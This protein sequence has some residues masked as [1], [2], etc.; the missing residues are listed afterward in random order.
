MLRPPRPPSPRTVTVVSPP[1]RS[2][3]G[4]GTRLAVL[5][6]LQRDPGHD[7]ADLARLA[8]ERVA[9][10]QRR[11]AR[12]PRDLGRGLQARLGAGDH[13]GLV[14]GQP[15]VAGLGRLLRGALRGG[16]G[17]PAAAR[18]GSGPGCRARPRRWRG[19]VPWAP[20]RWPLGSSP[21]TSE[22]RSVTTL[23]GCAAAA[24]LPPLIAERCFLT[25]RSS[26]RCRRPRR[27]APCSTA[28]LSSSESPSAG[29]ARSAEPPPEIRQSTR[30]SGPAP[31]ASS[32][33]RRAA[34]RP[35]ASGTGCE[36]STISIR[37]A[38]CGVAVA[39]DDQAL[40]RSRPVVLDRL[41]HRG[42]GLAGAQHD[43]AALGRRREVGRHDPLRQR[44]RDRRVQHGAEQ[45]PRGRSRCRHGTSPCCDPV[46]TARPG[47][48]IDRAG[49]ARRCGRSG[50]VA[51]RRPRRRTRRARDCRRAAPRSRR[52]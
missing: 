44:R 45:F 18:C 41:R 30:S 24:S 25:R 51:V 7:P 46:G 42:A 19:R 5:A 34:S 29:S 33:M 50:P 38:G 10:D 43:R 28:C 2:T 9:Q 11:V 12:L 32:R 37:V 21:G 40:E 52:R 27:G 26:G 20:T 14:A 17:R 47:S 48:T 3:Q 4:A 36:A 31:R 6:H 49:H 8:L 15:R 23:A 1:E 13:D 39:G 16:R 22:I 35:A